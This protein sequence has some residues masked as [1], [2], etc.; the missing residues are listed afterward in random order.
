MKDLGQRLYNEKHFDFS[1]VFINQIL[2]KTEGHEV[3]L[4]CKV[5]HDEVFYHATLCMGLRHFNDLLMASHDG[6][7]RRE[8]SSLMGEALSM[9]DQRKAQTTFQID[10]TKIFERPLR[11]QKC[12]YKT[13]LIT[14]SLPELNNTD[15][16]AYVFMVRQLQFAKQ[17]RA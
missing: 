14:L 12:T 9:E 13:R 7:L 10:I 16:E 4:V 8:I 1:S 5:I 2:F 3:L 6:E 17:Q 11:I 15:E